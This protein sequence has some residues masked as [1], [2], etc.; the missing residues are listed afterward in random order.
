MGKSFPHVNNA[1]PLRYSTQSLA[2]KKFDVLR[3]AYQN[4][5]KR[6]IEKL[7]SQSSRQLLQCSFFCQEKIQYSF[8]QEYGKWQLYKP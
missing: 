1:V 5:S 4:M 6:A 2:L 3:P 8:K 7:M